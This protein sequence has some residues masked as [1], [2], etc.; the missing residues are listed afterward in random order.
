[1]NL[2]ASPA[3]ITCMDTLREPTPDLDGFQLPPF[4]ATRAAWE[5]AFAALRTV[6]LSW[7]QILTGYAQAM[8]HNRGFPDI[9]MLRTW[10]E[11][12][13]LLPADVTAEAILVRMAPVVETF[14]EH[15]DFDKEA[16]RSMALRDLSVERDVLQFVGSAPWDQ[17]IGR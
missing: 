11:A 16:Q 10:C 6:H 14:A 9:L 17:G 1:M 12:Q 5:K 13:G 3:I 2:L 15:P 4:G 7:P 8:S